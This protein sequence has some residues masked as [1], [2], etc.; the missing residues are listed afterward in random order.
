[1]SRTSSYIKKCNDCEDLINLL[2]KIDD[3][4]SFTA[5]ECSNNL[6]YDLGTE[7]PDEIVDRIV[8][9]K[10]IILKRMFNPDYL[11]KL[12]NSLIISRVNSLLNQ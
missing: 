9:Y 12:P 8:R 10:S 3:Y 4:L 7:T 1:M 11:W 6:R 2:S 5:K